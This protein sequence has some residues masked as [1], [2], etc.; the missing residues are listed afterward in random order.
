MSTENKDSGYE[1]YADQG[2]TDVSSVEV[3]EPK[4]G[5]LEVY[6]NFVHVD[7]TPSDVRIR[8]DFLHYMTD[9]DEPKVKNQK[10]VIEE[11]CAVSVPWIQAK[12]LRD[13]LSF[14]INSYESVN[15]ELKLI[16]MPSSPPPAPESKES[17][18]T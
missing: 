8:F 18:E 13:Q 11:R 3:I 4:D 10:G 2:T 5:I 16:T 17:L 6:S 14:M 1:G 15:G 9:P 7:W 12:I